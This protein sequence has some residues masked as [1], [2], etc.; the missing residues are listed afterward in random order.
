MLLSDT[1]CRAIRWQARMPAVSVR[2][3]RW[4]LP[5]HRHNADFGPAEPG[6]CL[7]LCE[8]LQRPRD[9][10]HVYPVPPSH[11]ATTW[12]ARQIGRLPPFPFYYCNCYRRPSSNSQLGTFLGRDALCT[13][14]AQ[15]QE[16]GSPVPTTV[17]AVQR[18]DPSLAE[19]PDPPVPARHALRNS[20]LSRLII[21]Y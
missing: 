2:L 13:H 7:S 17:L 21:D 3:A 15:G 8:D 18:L 19:D 1:G 5:S 12:A 9:Q 14:V 4:E 6:T 11:L 10:E 20:S 16:T